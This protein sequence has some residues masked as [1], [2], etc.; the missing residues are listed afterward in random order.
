MDFFSKK[1]P[2]LQDLENS[3]PIDIAKTGN[4]KDVGPKAQHSVNKVARDSSSLSP[5]WGHG[6]ET[7]I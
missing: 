6:K 2:E 1:E 5:M 7:V 3:D 4:T